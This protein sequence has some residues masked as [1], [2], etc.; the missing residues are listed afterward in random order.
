MT[1]YV[2]YDF[3]NLSLLVF[4]LVLSRSTFVN[5]VTLFKELNFNSI[6]SVIFLLFISFIFSSISIISFLLLF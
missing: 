4:F 3:S 6:F 1:H 2:S 5:C